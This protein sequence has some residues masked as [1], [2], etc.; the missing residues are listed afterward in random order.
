MAEDPTDHV[1]ALL[2]EFRA[3]KAE[4]DRIEAA[5]AALGHQVAPVAGHRS[6]REHVLDLMREH[7]DWTWTAPQIIKELMDPKVNLP[8]N[9]PQHAIRSAIHN[10][11][12]RGE[13][14]RVRTGEYRLANP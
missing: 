13:L 8:T 11:L 5:L 12:K 10:A 3:A 1:V 7:P 6:V 9:D 14:K 4:V 2:Q